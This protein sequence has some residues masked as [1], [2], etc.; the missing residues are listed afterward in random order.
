LGLEKLLCPETEQLGNK[1]RLK[2]LYPHKIERVSV[3][4]EIIACNKEFT[5]DCAAEE[6]I[7][8]I[9]DHLIFT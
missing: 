9:L 1:Y 5:D 6:D 3:S 2:N 7:A 8:A 4:F